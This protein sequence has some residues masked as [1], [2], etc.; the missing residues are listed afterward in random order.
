MLTLADCCS[1]R[2]QFLAPVVRVFRGSGRSQVRCPEE[3]RVHSYV[4]RKAGVKVAAPPQ[5]QKTGTFEGC[6]GGGGR[7]ADDG[8]QTT[9]PTVASP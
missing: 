1:H 9:A 6:E 8:G 4:V 7:R 3:I 5:C 2:L